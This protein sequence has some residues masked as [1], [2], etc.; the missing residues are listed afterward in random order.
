MLLSFLDRQTQKC[1][2][3]FHSNTLT[4]PE[5]YVQLFS[6]LNLPQLCHPRSLQACFSHFQIHLG[7]SPKELSTG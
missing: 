7:M 3:S 6:A 4:Q 2:E 5:C 1:C